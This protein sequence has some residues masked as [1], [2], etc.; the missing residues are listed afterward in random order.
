MDGGIRCMK[1]FAPLTLP[2]WT[3][4]RSLKGGSMKKH[5]GESFSNN[6]RRILLPIIDYEKLIKL[7]QVAVT[8]NINTNDCQ[9]QLAR[10]SYCDT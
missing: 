9:R 2:S 6:F 7:C 10:L 1:E 5:A 4:G 8:N 3:L